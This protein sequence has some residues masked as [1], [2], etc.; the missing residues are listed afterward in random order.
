[1]DPWTKICLHEP[2]QAIGSGTGRKPQ[3]VRTVESGCFKNDL[4]ICLITLVDNEKAGLRLNIIKDFVESQINGHG[5]SLAHL[6]V[7]IPN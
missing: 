6:L 4:Q 2:G 7:T 5:K 1:M 3:K